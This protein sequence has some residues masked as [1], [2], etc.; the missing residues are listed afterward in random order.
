MWS[1][2]TLEPLKGQDLSIAD[3]LLDYGCWCQIRNQ[4]GGFFTGH[5]TPVDALDLACK[6]WYQCKACTT[7]DFSA[8]SPRAGYQIDFHPITQRIDCTSNSSE[9]SVRILL[10]FRSEKKY[11]FQEK[12]CQCD[13]QLAYTLSNL[14]STVYNDD[15]HN[16]DHLN[17]CRASTGSGSGGNAGVDNARV[18]CCG[19]Y[20]NRFT[21]SSE[22]GLRS[23][24]D[25]V[26][27][28]I[29]QHDCCLGEN[30]VATLKDFG[31]CT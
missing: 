31:T 29:F 22:S 23:C 27:F 25:S 20:P 1:T 13:E 24:C 6:S 18:E 11:F 12:N 28:D 7:I 19:N 4:S 30:G 26:T 15:Y 16:F 9:C 3:K 5:G 14:A 2:N 10:K 17:E 8:C 21:Y